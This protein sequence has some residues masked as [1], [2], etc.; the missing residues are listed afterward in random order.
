M[1]CE[2]I[3]SYKEGTLYS[4]PANKAPSSR[5]GTSPSDQ[6]KNK[7]GRDDRPIA[8]TTS[9]YMPRMSKPRPCSEG[10]SLPSMQSHMY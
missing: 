1:N 2:H 9:T 3:T 7:K 10:G 4:M 5:S 8:P 6:G